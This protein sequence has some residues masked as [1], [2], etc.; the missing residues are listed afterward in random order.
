MVRKIAM[1]KKRL[2]AGGRGEPGNLV[3]H[4]PEIGRH[5]Y[6]AQPERSKHQPEHLAPI[7]EM[8]KDATAPGDAARGKRRRQRRDEAIDLAPGPGP[9]APDQADTLAMPEGILG[10]A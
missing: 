8:N 7:L 2:G 4:Q 9:L 6:R 10:E 5:P 3:R 1:T